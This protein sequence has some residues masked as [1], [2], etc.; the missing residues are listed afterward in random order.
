MSGALGVPI[1]AHAW[2]ILTFPF[3]Q[4]SLRVRLDWPQLITVDD[5]D[6]IA[7]IHDDMYGAWLMVHIIISRG[8]HHQPRPMHIM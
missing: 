7:Y 3:P 1:Y 4:Q 6:A 5:V 8:V 2:D